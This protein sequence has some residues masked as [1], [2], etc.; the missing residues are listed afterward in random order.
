MLSILWMIIIGFIAGAI[1]RWLLPGV[2]AMGFWLTTGLGIAGSFVGGLI[3][4]VFSKP[5]DGSAFGP[6]GIIM[7]IVGA[8]IVLYVARMMR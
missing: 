7:S 3:S 8:M 1:A 4:R 6:A 2:D 5:A